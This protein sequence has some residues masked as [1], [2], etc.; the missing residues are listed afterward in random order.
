MCPGINIQDP[1]F[2]HSSWIAYETIRDAQLATELRL[3]VKAHSAEDSLLLYNG[4]DGAERQD[5][6]SLAIRGGRV[7][8]RY[9]SGSGEA[10]LHLSIPVISHLI[11]W[12]LIFRQCS[13][14]YCAHVKHWVLCLHCVCV[15][16]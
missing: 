8:F 15:F 7:E 10:I 5:F 3:L 1:S 6:I 14:G 16:V 9:D 13:Y 2:N 11:Y 4:Q 12:G